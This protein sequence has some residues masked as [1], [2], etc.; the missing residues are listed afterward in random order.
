MSRA[1]LV[2]ILSLVCFPIIENLEIF[3]GCLMSLLNP[4]PQAS[5][6]GRTRHVLSFLA[7]HNAVL[8]ET[9]EWSDRLAVAM[10]TALILSWIFR[11]DYP[12]SMKAI[13]EGVHVV[14]AML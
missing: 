5:F 1:V 13:A 2:D 8:K 14:S 3:Y 4:G 10:T 12:E 9:F 7:H 6:S 11:K